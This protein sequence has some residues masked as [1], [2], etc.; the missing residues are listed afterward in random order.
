MDRSR[1]PK[2]YKK[3]IPERLDILREKGILNKEDYFTFF[4]GENVLTNAEA[5]KKFEEVVKV[6][7]QADAMVHATR[8]QIEEA[9]DAL[10]SD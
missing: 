9:G 8:K 1:I 2:F 7:N 3:S 10:A 5:D 6:R 4:N